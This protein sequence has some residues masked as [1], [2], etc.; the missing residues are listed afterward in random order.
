MLENKVRRKIH[1]QILGL[2]FSAVQR[3]FDGS[4]GERRHFLSGLMPRQLPFCGINGGRLACRCAI[5]QIKSVDP[6]LGQQD[7]H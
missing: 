3:G 6:V 5:V 4:A 2:S 7:F 1:S